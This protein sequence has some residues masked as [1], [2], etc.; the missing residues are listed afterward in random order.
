[1][2]G[3]SKQKVP[4]NLSLPESVVERYHYEANHHRKKRKFTE[5]NVP[6]D[7]SVGYDGDELTDEQVRLVEQYLAWRHYEPVKRHF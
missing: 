5:G 7:V 1:M 4:V 3:D 6:V 2:I